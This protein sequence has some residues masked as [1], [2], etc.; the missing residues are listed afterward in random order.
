LDK[1]KG[2]WDEWLADDVQFMNTTAMVQNDK[3]IAFL[4][5]EIYMN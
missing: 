1:E 4:Q 3:Y 2:W 5:M